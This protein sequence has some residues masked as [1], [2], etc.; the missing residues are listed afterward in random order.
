MLDGRALKEG[1]LGVGALLRQYLYD[2]QDFYCTE[3]ANTLDNL[4]KPLMKA[5]HG[6]LSA[7]DEDLI[8]ASLKS[9]GYV[10]YINSDLEDLI[11]QI[12][13][14]K[15]TIQRI[16]AA[17]LSM[18]KIYAKNPKVRILY[19]SR[20]SRSL[21]NTYVKISHSIIIYYIYST[22]HESNI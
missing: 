15:N 7:D 17:S 21:S 1:Y 5:G 13:M 3:V 4:G 9:I 2:T 22:L 14:D 16:K 6:P 10:Q 11:I 18:L 19:L 20:T 12:T 8:I